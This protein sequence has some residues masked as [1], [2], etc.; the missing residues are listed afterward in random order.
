MTSYPA[1]VQEL[2]ME[3]SNLREAF[4]EYIE[5]SRELENGLDRELVDM[6]T[7]LIEQLISLVYM[8]ENSRNEFLVATTEGK[9]TQSSAANETLGSQL[10]TI[11]PQL[12]NLEASLGVTKKKLKEE[13]RLRR[14]AEL[15]QVELETRYKE[16]EANMFS[17]REE[18]ESLRTECDALHEELTFKCRELEDSKNEQKVRRKLLGN[19]M[20]SSDQKRE[21]RNGK[22]SI[23]SDA[24]LE[25]SH[26]DTETVSNKTDRTKG[27][28]TGDDSYAEVLDELE[29]VT[30]QLI[31]TQKKL[32]TTEDNLRSSDARVRKLEAYRKDKKRSG[33]KL[34]SLAD[35]DQGEDDSHSEAEVRDELS[36]LKDELSL[37]HGEL[38]AATEQAESYQA[39]LTTL[40]KSKAIREDGAKLA[41]ID[42]QKS[43]IEDLK[44][45]VRELEYSARST[46][47]ELAEKE[48]ILAESRE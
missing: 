25:L 24:A 18:N 7:Y 45:Q 33:K 15:A 28:P 14:Q 1:R 21:E 5:S 19:R 9:L 41:G 30:E 26:C 38:R 8:M 48:D 32:W 10:E 3:L 43:N 27:D 35:D 17:L 34:R 16:S 4:E 23:R 44:E 36:V 13:S 12:G 40:E 20:G 31:A 6:R 2:E 11:E 46:E 47:Q 42:N 39:R 22:S 37:A 29:T